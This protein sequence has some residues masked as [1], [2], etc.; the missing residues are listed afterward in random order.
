MKKVNLRIA[1]L[2][3]IGLALFSCSKEDQP[4]PQV[5]DSPIVVQSIT[6]TG[7]NSSGELKLDLTGYWSLDSS[8][9]VDLV[10][11]MT[12]H[13][14]YLNIVGDTM[15]NISSIP[16]SKKWTYFQ[17]DKMFIACVDNQGNEFMYLVLDVSS[18]NLTLNR[19]DYV[20]GMEQLIY[21]SK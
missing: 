7:G 3:I 6:Q 13:N 11:N 19:I 21:Y 18:N 15:F 8:I 4:K 17:I 14:N 16:D 10:F 2:L 9:V 20:T 12:T 5:I 1:M